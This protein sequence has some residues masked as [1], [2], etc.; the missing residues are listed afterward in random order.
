MDRVDCMN[1]RNQQSQTE[2]MKIIAHRGWS[3][4]HPELTEAALVSALEYGADGV[5]ID[6]RLTKDGIPVLI[7]DPVL[8]RV[9]DGQGRVSPRTLAE[10]KE[11]NFGT[12]QEPQ[13]V[14]TL[15]EAL[16]IVEPYPHAHLFIEAKHPIRYGRILEEQITNTL[17]YHGKLNDETIHFI[18][19]STSSIVRLRY[20]APKL[21]RI[22]LRRSW[23]RWLNPVARFKGAPTG[24]GFEI[25]R[26]QRNPDFV[27][28]YG[29]PTYAWT[30]DEP[31]QMRWALEH[32]VSY[33]ATNDVAVAMDVC[34]VVR[35]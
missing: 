34:A 2:R 24:L 8:N 28:C 19:F 23:E 11:L 17:L 33:M 12:P 27:N 20:L 26:L 16:E 21:D 18:S 35:Q 4:K 3:K 25:N 32:G 15:G 31:E 5:E 7:H 30:V 22:H 9:S 13:Q 6:V 29:K 1:H 10:L 14:L